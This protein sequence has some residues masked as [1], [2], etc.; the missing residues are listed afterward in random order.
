[1]NQT[2]RMA[3]VEITPLRTWDDFFPGS[4]RFGKPDVK[5]PAKWSNRVISNLLYYQTNYLAVAV[6]AFLIVGFMEPLGM[7]TAI[8]AVS[9]V[10]CGSAWIAE[11]R[12]VLS[13]LKR[14]NPAAFLIVVVVASYVLIS[15]LGCVM[16]FV[17]AITLPLTLIFVHASLRLRN[18][19]NK[20]EN[21]IECAGLKRS[22]MGM[23]LE[24]LGQQEENV[25]KIQSFLEGKLKE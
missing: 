9:G 7:F 14:E 19:K 23:L 24:A 13:H 12:N 2:T 21:K 5:D 11:N 17:T 8:A 1:M 4:E 15:L 18:M 6:L 20:L 16:V 10:C 22:P 3:K 25:Q